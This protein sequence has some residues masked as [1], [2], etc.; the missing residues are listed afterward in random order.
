MRRQY[1]RLKRRRFRTRPGTKTHHAAPSSAGSRRRG[2]PGLKETPT[3]R[4]DISAQ[5][6]MH[7]FE[8]TKRRSSVPDAMRAAALSEREEML[9]DEIRFASEAPSYRRRQ[10]TEVEL[11][12]IRR[13]LELLGFPRTLS[14]P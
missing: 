11:S 8:N 3:G 2:N 13:D 4:Y 14:T 7:R 5:P 1:S 12:D 6:N 10:E 9:V